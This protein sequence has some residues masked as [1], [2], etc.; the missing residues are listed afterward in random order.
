MADQEPR[1]T[2]S[3]SQ[4]K[5]RE[6]VAIE[7]VLGEIGETLTLLTS[8]KRRLGELDGSLKDAAR[9][10][11]RA[12]Q[13]LETTAKDVLGRQEELER[14]AV[15][16][17]LTFAKGFSEYCSDLSAKIVRSAVLG[18][19]GGGIMGGLII[20]GAWFITHR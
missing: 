12:A 9:S 19:L 10:L 13:S 1:S 11:T 14:K 20:L 4:H 16:S 18:S 8:T 2:P 15:E 7:W 3:P 6:E 17:R 5:T